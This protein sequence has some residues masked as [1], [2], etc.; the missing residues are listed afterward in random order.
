MIEA[1]ILCAILLICLVVGMTLY[2]I[3]L[4]SE[5]DDE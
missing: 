3:A 2:W 1:I 5:D 4:V